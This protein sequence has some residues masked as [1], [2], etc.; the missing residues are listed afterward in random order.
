M[1]SLVIWNSY[2][3]VRNKV[4]ATLSVYPVLSAFQ[5]SCAKCT[6]KADPIGRARVA[7]FRF[8]F[9]SL[10]L[11]CKRIFCDTE[12]VSKTE[13]EGMETAVSSLLGLNFGLFL[14][15]CSG[16]ISQTISAIIYVARKFLGIVL[17]VDCESHVEINTNK[18]SP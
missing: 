6:K 3:W 12:T 4:D 10:K 15:G 16:G 9:L 7:E 13:I 1:A 2:N 8:N 14:L 5:L 18:R 17:C 11:K